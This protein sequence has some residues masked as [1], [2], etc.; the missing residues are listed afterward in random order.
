MLDEP[1]R[2][3]NLLRRV[4]AKADEY[5]GRRL[6]R[7]LAVIFFLFV[8]IGTVGGMIYNTASIPTLTNNTDGT[9]E[10]VEEKHYE[11]R[12]TY[13]NP[14]FYPNDDVSYSLTD[15][16]GETV[17][18]LT[19]EDQKLV[20]SEGHYAKVYGSLKKTEDGKEDILVVDRLVIQ[21]AP[22]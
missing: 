10:Q 13:V 21:N 11:G 7:L 3:Q 16:S 8:V 9:V 5:K 22:N 12:I 2:K 14:N 17:V 4:S 6:A 1:A 19:A 18:L 20:V 15:G